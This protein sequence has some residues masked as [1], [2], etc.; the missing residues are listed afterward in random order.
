MAL[1]HRGLRVFKYPELDQKEGSPHMEPQNRL[2]KRK[3]TAQREGEKEKQGMGCS[4]SCQDSAA[5]SVQ[6]KKKREKDG[7]CV[8]RGYMGVKEKVMRPNIPH[9]RSCCPH[10]NMLNLSVLLSATSFLEP[11][12]QT[13]ASLP[14]LI[15]SPSHQR[16]FLHAQKSWSQNTD[17]KVRNWSVLLVWRIIPECSKHIQIEWRW[18][19]SQ[20]RGIL[21]FCR[22]KRGH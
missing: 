11:A 4:F 21:C 15:L 22:R 18:R 1:F 9:N 10:V 5:K 20:K 7:V 13:E 3:Q 14:T 16:H 6:T 19:G 12:G 17:L 2:K 8:C